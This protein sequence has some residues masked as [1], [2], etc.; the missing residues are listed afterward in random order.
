MENRILV[1]FEVLEQVITLRTI[2][3]KFK[4]P[5]SFYILK[6][7]ILE[8][9]DSKWMVVNDG[10]SFAVL[11]LEKTEDGSS[12]LRIAFSWLS[13]EGNGAI[14]GRREHIAVPFDRFYK[15][16]L[17]A[18]EDAD[19]EADREWKVLSLGNKSMPRIEFN[20]RRNLREVAKHPRLRKK[21]GKFLSTHFQWHGSQRI[22]LYDD[23]LFD[24]YFQEYIGG[25]PG[26]CGGVI[27]H[28]AA[29][30]RT[31]F[32]GIHT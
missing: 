2:S 15:A 7:R 14:T 17:P 22:V 24:F 21:L 19:T 25:K 4:A 23:S 16:A 3:R 5:H 28:G 18:Q 9:A 27:L 13:E 8:L 32:Y 26:M 29:D 20:S 12:I 31:A 10:S 11:S 30:L 1:K 6:K